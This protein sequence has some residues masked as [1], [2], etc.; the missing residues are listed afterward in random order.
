[1]ADQETIDAVRARRARKMA[2]QPAPK[3]APAG[4][5]PTPADAP[6]KPSAVGSFFRGLGQGASFGFGDE[7]AGAWRASLEPLAARW[8]GVDPSFIPSAGEAY[9]QSRDDY[10]GVLEEDMKENPLATIGG[11]VAGGVAVPMGFGLKAATLGGQVLRGAA[12]GAGA[13]ALQGAGDAPEMADIPESSLK[14]AA[15]G[16]AVGGALPLAAKGAGAVV[17][18][19]PKARDAVVS[20]ADK[21]VGAAEGSPMAR[22]GAAAVS[23]GKSEGLVAAA[24]LAQK[25]RRKPAA[26]PAAPQVPGLQSL[27]D[28]I[29]TPTGS[30][31]GLDLEDVT[32]QIDE[33][34]GKPA[35][36]EAP[37]VN[38]DEGDALERALM[39]VTPEK[40]LVDSSPAS[41][42]DIA[43]ALAWEERK[44]AAR[45]APA[46]P[47]SAEMA[48]GQTK[49][50][51]LG[52]AARIARSEVGQEAGTGS[53]RAP[54]PPPK[55]LPEGVEKIGT[56]EK[57]GDPGRKTL[58]ITAADPPATPSDRRPMVADPLERAQAGAFDLPPLAEPT[59]QQIRGRAPAPPER[60]EGWNAAA[61]DP[62]WTPPKQ[63]EGIDPETLAPSF[64][65]GKMREWWEVGPET[66][67]GARNDFNRN[68]D[69]EATKEIR[70][71]ALDA[72]K[73]LS[74]RGSGPD[75]EAGDLL[76]RAEKQADPFDSFFQQDFAQGPKLN[77]PQAYAT[78]IA[79]AKASG[80]PRE[81]ARA[82]AEKAGWPPEVMQWLG[83]GDAAPA[84]KPIRK[85]GGP[86]K[87]KPGMLRMA[88]GE[89]P[90]DESIEQGFVRAS[91]AGAEEEAA[92][93]EQQLRRLLRQR[94]LT[95]K[96]YAWAEKQRGRIDQIRGKKSRLLD[97][98]VTP[99]V[100]GAAAAREE[101]RQALAR[102]KTK[103]PK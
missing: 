70:P 81:Q 71:G 84:P 32:R 77:D 49:P 76:T 101:A 5:R 80:M 14:G 99:P 44:A 74:R 56:W 96:D 54:K 35:P 3:A 42:D 4:L 22:A 30:P 34:R 91:T 47:P 39:E 18:A 12:I 31:S 15:I 83:L 87:P 63:W 8:H 90:V 17:R 65:G 94:N 102:Y 21:V 52:E 23:G 41:G 59:T 67:M 68:V 43:E 20:G 7:A 103:A 1:M 25:L 64:Q 50:M 48:T 97:Y 19:L 46:R 37:T 13:G 61:H 89:F 93:L 11:N 88:A 62:D 66:K 95:A 79:K 55:G 29:G 26:P 86:E 10:R 27:A 57:G 9:K 98:E 36:T 69:P 40:P 82:L 38:L 92:F 73:N 33:L 51:D 60:W 6:E 72:L 100:D 24:K 75:M 28:D 85:K 2:S 16:G 58:P 45:M 53:M 78:I